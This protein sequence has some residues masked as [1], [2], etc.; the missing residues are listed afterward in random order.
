MLSISYQSCKCV[1]DLAVADLAGDLLLF[2]PSLPPLPL[3]ALSA[4]LPMSATLEFLCLSFLCMHHMLPK[5][6]ANET[7]AQVWFESFVEAVVCHCA[8]LNVLS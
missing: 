8:F 3:L 6:L 1:Q 7:H 4:L 5:A 2:C